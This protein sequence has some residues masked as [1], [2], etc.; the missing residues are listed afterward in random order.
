MESSCLPKSKEST[1]DELH[2]THR[3]GSIITAP[4]S[5][6]TKFMG[7]ESD[8][9]LQQEILWAVEFYS[10]KCRT[11]QSDPSVYQYLE[12]EAS[13]GMAYLGSSSRYKTSTV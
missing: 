8:H 13:I 12:I 5:L 1:E 4:L 2:H 9:V 7:Y 11:N 10:R 6:T 3:N